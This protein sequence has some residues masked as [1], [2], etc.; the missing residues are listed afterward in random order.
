MVEAGNIEAGAKPDILYNGQNTKEESI[1]FL[2]DNGFKVIDIENN[3]IHGNEV[4]IH[5]VK[6]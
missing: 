3:D 6:K 4:N 2:E 5:F 1:Q